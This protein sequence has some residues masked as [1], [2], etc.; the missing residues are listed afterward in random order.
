MQKIKWSYVQRLMIL[1]FWSQ[2]IFDLMV[3]ILLNFWSCYL[4]SKNFMICWFWS[5]KFFDLQV[6]VLIHLVWKLWINFTSNGYELNMFT[7]FILFFEREARSNG[8]FLRVNGISFNHYFLSFTRYEATVKS[9]L[10]KNISSLALEIMS[11]GR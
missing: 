10:L 6:L 1:W 4:G 5:Q 3:L 9:L 7:T 2:E 11:V 8:L